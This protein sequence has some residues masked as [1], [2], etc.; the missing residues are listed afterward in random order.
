MDVGQ[1]VASLGQL[2]GNLAQYVLAAVQNA[3][4]WL[5]TLAVSLMSWLPDHVPIAWPD[6]AS[7]ALAFRGLGLVG[8]FVDLPFLFVVL[9]LVMTW[10]IVVLAYG[11]YR[12]VLGFIPTFK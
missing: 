5:I 8:R 1:V 2:A 12:V 7:W 4:A 3:I 10:H 11:V 6:P 9:G